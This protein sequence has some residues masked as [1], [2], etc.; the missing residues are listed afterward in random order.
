MDE[1]VQLLKDIRDLLVRAEHR[2]MY[3][4]MPTIEP[5]KP[6]PWVGP[7]CDGTGSPPPGQTMIY[8]KKDGN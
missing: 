7:T 8:A 6:Y 4:K 3:L 5:W 1:V 2:D